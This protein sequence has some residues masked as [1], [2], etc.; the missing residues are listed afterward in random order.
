[1]IKAQF[2]AI[3][4]NDRASFL[5]N[6]FALEKFTAPYHFHPEYELT[7]ITE[8]TGTRFVGKSMQEYGPGDLVFLGAGLPHCWKSEDIVRGELR[9]HSVLVQFENAFLGPEFFAKPELESIEG[10]LHRSASGI[11]FLG[12]TMTE[13]T[14]RMKALSF[15]E[16]RFKRML[17]LLEILDIL[18]NSGDY[19][20]LDSDGITAGSVP[21]ERE[22]VNTSLGYIVDN[23][24][25]KIVLD[26]VAA[27]VNMSVG[28]F[29]KYFRRATGKTFI[30]TVTDYRVHFATKQ[31]LATD[32]SMTE[33]AFDSGFGDVSHFFR[34]FRRRLKT[35]P[36]QYRKKF[37]KMV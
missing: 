22:R 16:S 11:R 36:L 33:I 14:A 9:S 18:A 32:K 35:S 19:L 2:E 23:F 27:A 7:W 5:V 13:V 3:T 12:N 8:G 24:R 21:G 10:L 26:E 15:E 17:G 4:R 31:L 37:L 30:E 34:V 29:C 1:M 6:T 20:L 25:D 28:A